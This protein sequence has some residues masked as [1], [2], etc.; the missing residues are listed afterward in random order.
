[1][2]ARGAV[3]QSLASISL[4]GREGT[5]AQ[6]GCRRRHSCNTD[7]GPRTVSCTRGCLQEEGH[8]PPERGDE[9]KGASSRRLL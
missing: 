2:L 9:E 8:R 4:E 3:K 1:M 6:S 7:E 5:E